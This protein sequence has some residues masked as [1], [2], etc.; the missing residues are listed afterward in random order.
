M[1]SAIIANRK[2]LAGLVIGAA[3][4]LFILLWFLADGFNASVVDYLNGHGG[5]ALLFL[6]AATLILGFLAYVF[7]D[8][9]VIIAF[10]VV[11]IFAVI[12]MF[13]GMEIPLPA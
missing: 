13:V 2:L 5:Y 10:F 9:R 12:A 6:L 8:N 4:V 7:R 1:V 11:G 3:A